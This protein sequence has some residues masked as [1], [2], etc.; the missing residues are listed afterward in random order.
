MLIFFSDICFYLLRTDANRATTN[1]TQEEDNH[2]LNFSLM[3][4]CLSYPHDLLVILYFLCVYVNVTIR[5]H[6]FPCCLNIIDKTRSKIPFFF[7]VGFFK[8]CSFYHFVLHFFFSVRLKMYHSTRWQVDR[9]ISQ[10]NMDDLR[11]NLL[12]T[13]NAF[14]HVFLPI[15]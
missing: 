1:K 9:L 5:E 11:N 13:F 6:V 3:H 4:I 7:I 15:L 10:V 2:I 12:F 8:K 14:Y